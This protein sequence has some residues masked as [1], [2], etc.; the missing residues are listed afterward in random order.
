MT[1]CMPSQVA[2]TLVSLH[3][4]DNRMQEYKPL[5]TI[6]VPSDKIAE[7]VNSFLLE[8]VEVK[9]FYKYSWEEPGSIGGLYCV[10]PAV[11]DNIEIS[12]L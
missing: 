10:S 1:V 9:E 7:V 11:F 12:Q 6:R 3:K 4:F 8:R 5:R 2:T